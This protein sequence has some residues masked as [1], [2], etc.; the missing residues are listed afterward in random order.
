M[1]FTERSWQAIL[2]I[3]DA[4]LAHPFV[5]G[6]TDGSL[7]IEAFRFYAVQDALYLQDYA[8]GLAI[9]AGK[10]H[11]DNDVIMFCEHA[12]NAI[13]VERALHESFFSAWGLSSQDV[14]DQPKAPNCVLYTDYLMRV[15]LE[16]PFEEGVAAFLPCYWIY[17]AV[18]QALL[19]SGSSH[20]QFQ[21]WINTYADDEF[22]SLV[23]TVKTLANR[24]AET[25]TEATRGRM[26]EHFVMT[27]RF[28]WM[29]WDM[30]YRQQSWP[31]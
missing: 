18:G 13:Q 24:L 17:M 4:I 15:A 21:A 10:A 31:V 29:F 9:L 26:V 8:R 27:S 19:Q 14:Y 22:A 23:E 28:E 25:S 7:S 1:T 16:R 30:G 20:P 11:D 6:L 2:P 12:A 3:Y 5:K